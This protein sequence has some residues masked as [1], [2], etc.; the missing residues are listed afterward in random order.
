MKYIMMLH[1]PRTGYEALGA[2]PKKDFQ[3]HI[4]FMHSF[5]K[6]LREAGEM[7]SAEGLADPK[8]ATIV[9]AGKDGEPITDGV[10]P[11]SKEFLAGYWIVDV[12][13]TERAYQLAAQ[14]S[15]APGPDGAPLNMPIEVRQVMSGPPEEFV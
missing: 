6:Q 14:A 9:R 5:N 13:S 15:T 11:E 7:V 3:A 12:E 2:W 10:F 1:S 8:Q 4:A